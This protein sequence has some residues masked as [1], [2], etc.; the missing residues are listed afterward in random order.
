MKLKQL[1]HLSTLKNARILPRQLTLMMIEE[2][3]HVCLITPSNLNTERTTSIF[4]AAIATT[5]DES[6]PFFTNLDSRAVQLVQE[7]RFKNDPIK[8][9]FFENKQTPC[10]PQPKMYQETRF[11][12]ILRRFKSS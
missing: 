2:A 10:Q 3:K 4:G 12:S 11:G 7:K 9:S 6:R 5:D 1:K 8:P